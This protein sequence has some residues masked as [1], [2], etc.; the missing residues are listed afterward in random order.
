MSLQEIISSQSQKRERT[1]P[2][3]PA[4]A[5]ATSSAAAFSSGA[6]SV[7]QG[8][9][10]L[11]LHPPPLGGGGGGVGLLP[12]QPPHSQ[13]PRNPAQPP[14]PPP[15][16]SSS[17]SSASSSRP[18]SELG[19]SAADAVASMGGV[20]SVDGGVVNSFYS[21]LV[22]SVSWQCSFRSSATDSLRIVPQRS[23]DQ[24]AT[25]GHFLGDAYQQHQREQQC[26]QRGHRPGRFGRIQR[27]YLLR[28]RCFE[29]L[30]VRRLDVVGDHDFV[31]RR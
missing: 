30:L 7:L 3:P 27:L 26:K 17:A 16:S 22:D 11:S 12:P 20:S 1:P 21:E 18:S 10:G 15:H 19:D 13:Q 4:A 25:A 28:R 31:W 29:V 8:F 5:A 6:T 23:H 14:P 9:A 2:P 24:A